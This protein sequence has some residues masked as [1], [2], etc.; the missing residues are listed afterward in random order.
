MSGVGEGDR[1][2]WILQISRRRAGS[3]GI[4]REREERGKRQKTARKPR[5]SFHAMPEEVRRGGGI[6]P[7]RPERFPGKERRQREPENAHDE[8]GN[9]LL[10]R[11]NIKKNLEKRSGVSQK[12]METGRAPKCE[13]QIIRWLVVQRS[14]WQQRPSTEDKT[15][16]GGGRGDA[17]HSCP[18]FSF[19]FSFV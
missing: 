10:E 8:E 5:V 18:F 12:K 15:G 6:A 2:D 14:L 9:K 7:S 17:V 11:E 3:W 13:N 16:E 19:F 1:E 4:S